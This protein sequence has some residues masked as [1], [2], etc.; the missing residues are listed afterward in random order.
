MIRRGEGGGEWMGG[1]LWSPA[2]GDMIVFLQ[3]GSP[4]NRTRATIKAHTTQPNRPRPYGFDGLLLR[5]MR[6]GRLLRSPLRGGILRSGCKRLYS[7]QKGLE[8]GTTTPSPLDRLPQS[9]LLTCLV[10]FFLGATV[11]YPRTGVAFAHEYP[12]P[13][14]CYG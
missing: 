8:Y 14:R 7:Q 1:P 6:I 2:A 3:D 9:L 10:P 12:F 11:Q 5:L 13:T 4:G